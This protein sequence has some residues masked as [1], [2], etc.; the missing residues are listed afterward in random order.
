MQPH[1][2][3]ASV[4]RPRRLS[5]IL[6]TCAQSMQ[7]CKPQHGWH[8]RTLPT[9]NCGVPTNQAHFCP[10]L[11]HHITSLGANTLWAGQLHA[12]VPARYLCAVHRCCVISSSDSGDLQQCL[13][14]HKTGFAQQPTKLYGWT[15]RLQSGAF[16]TPHAHC[17]SHLNKPRGGD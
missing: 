9:R 13:P 8:T 7:S 1:I 15:W 16:S 5:C 2:T 4:L 11:P 17:D 3:N 6:D 10:D 14:Q 12:S